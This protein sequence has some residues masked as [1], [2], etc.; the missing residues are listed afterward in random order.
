ML[1]RLTMFLLN[2]ADG[3]FFVLLGPT[4]AGKTTTLRLIAG[5]EKL[6]AGAILF[7]GQVINE[8]DTGLARCGYGFPTILVVSQYVSL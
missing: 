8:F 2:I 7:D 4:G 3:E 5:L 1:R 6:D